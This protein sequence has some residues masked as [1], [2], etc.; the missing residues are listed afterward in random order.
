MA[1]IMNISAVAKVAPRVRALLAS[2]VARRR[3]RRRG[4]GIFRSYPIPLALDARAS[5][6]ALATRRAIARGRRYRAR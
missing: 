2:S 6:N 4:F 1:T 5:G 3:R